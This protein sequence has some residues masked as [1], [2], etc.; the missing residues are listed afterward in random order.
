MNWAASMKRSPVAC[1]PAL[2]PPAP[3][4]MPNVIKADAPLG[5]YFCA[6]AWYLPCGKPG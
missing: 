2:V 1:P 6:S 3:A 5:M 4:L